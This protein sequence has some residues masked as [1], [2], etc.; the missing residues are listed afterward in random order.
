MGNY[1]YFPGEDG[2]PNPAACKNGGSGC[3]A[4]KRGRIGCHCPPGWRGRRC[5]LRVKFKERDLRE[6]E[7]GFRKNKP[8]GVFCKGNYNFMYNY[9]CYRFVSDSP[10]SYNDAR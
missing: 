7:R 2:C 1:D 4:N 3:Q 9:H 5:G 10:K 8:E 6:R